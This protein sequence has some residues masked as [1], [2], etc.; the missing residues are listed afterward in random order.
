[1]FI[2]SLKA[3]T[4]K[5][6]ALAVASVLSLIALVL[7]IPNDTNNIAANE[8]SFINV[9]SSQNDNEFKYG[10]I[11]NADDMNAFIASLGWTVEENPN[12][13]VDVTIPA[14]FNNVY[15]KYN[16]IQKQ[17]GLNLEKYKGKSAKRYTYTV[18]NYP[19]TTKTV[20]LNL[21]IYKNK[22]IAGDVC[23]ADVNGFVHGIFYS[24][25]NQGN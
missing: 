14:E 23:T 11:K 21:I 1:M 4:I 18:T 9:N 13:I 10:K 16:D 15:L 3:S 8:F 20:Y 24:D 25:A 12:E 5:V 19:N 2:Y 17:Q 6:A 7:F 22:V